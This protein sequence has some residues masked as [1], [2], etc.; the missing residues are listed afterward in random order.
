MSR[1][2][3]EAARLRALTNPHY[4]CA[5]AVLLPF[6]KATGADEETVLKLA[7]AFGGGMR[8][9]SV[10]G[11]VTGA[12]MALGLFGADDPETVSRFQACF[13]EAH[14]G[15]LDCAELLEKN[16]LAGG[17]KK[18]FCNALVTE[19]AAMTE[20]IL[21]KK[22]KLPLKGE[23]AMKAKVYFTREITPESVVRLYE[24][25][26]KELPGKVA[27]KV[28]SGEAGNQNFL[29][30]DFWKPMVDK[31]DGTVV[32]C[33]TAYGGARN[34][35]K[36]HLQLLRQHGWN[37]YY[38]V[39]LM[40]ADGPDAELSIPDGKKIK[41]D[42]VGK[43]LMNYDSML[44]LAHFKGHPMGGFGGALKQL[45][46]GCASTAGKAYIHSAGRT[47]DQRECWNPPAPQLDFLESMADAAAA[48]TRHFEGR[49]A[50]IN[51]MKNMSVDCDCCAVAEDPCIKDIGVLASL[52]PIA[53]DQACVDLVY[54]AA[55]DPGQKHFLKRI[56]SRKGIH[57]VEAAAELG[58]GSREYELIEI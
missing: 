6:A 16:A 5:Q 31:V 4:N 28:H 12:L 47:T 13:A 36:K 24:A 14:E 33:N 39:D 43:D 20:R 3:E 46:I 38:T 56:E 8:R 26:G 2:T 19:S 49:I 52:D 48:V 22:G 1:F 54:K 34:E 11:A 18:P 58:F 9:G 25:L 51:V 55:D 23:T 21:L 45:S 32:E 35:T 30:P 42:L 7:S 44:V 53:I 29:R 17:A 41:K 37:R 15:C 27:V 57:T 50:F 10:C 40:D